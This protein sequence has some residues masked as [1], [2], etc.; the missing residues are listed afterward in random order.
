M[1]ERLANSHYLL[2][3]PAIA[4]S[5]QYT[6]GKSSGADLAVWRDSGILTLNYVCQQGKLEAEL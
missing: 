3:L 5:R 6:A 1:Q 2:L 4:N